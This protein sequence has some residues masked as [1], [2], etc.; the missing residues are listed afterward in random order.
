M[1]DQVSKTLYIVGAGGFVREIARL[2][3][4]INE[5]AISNGDDAPCEL[6]GFLDDKSIY[7]KELDECKTCGEHEGIKKYGVRTARGWYKSPK[8]NKECKFPKSSRRVS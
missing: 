5:A 1:C 6:N 4:K 8:V 7:I 3:E 2:V